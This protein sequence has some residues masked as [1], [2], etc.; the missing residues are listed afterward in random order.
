M[1]WSIVAGTVSVLLGM[2]ITLFVKD[3]ARA[4]VKEEFTELMKG[5]LLEF[6]IELTKSLDITYARNGECKLIRD[7]S[8]D[9]IDMHELRLN[10]I[11]SRFENL[12]KSLD[13]KND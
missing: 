8:D 11:D 12:H 3:K 10:A 4:V 5:V 9:R 7:A 2:L 6:K 1:N 13:K